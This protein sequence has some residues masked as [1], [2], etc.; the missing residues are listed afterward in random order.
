MPTG[1]LAANAS[2]P[3]SNSVSSS[4][5][6]LDKFVRLAVINLPSQPLDV[7]INQIAVRTKFILPDLLAEL[8]ARENSV[9]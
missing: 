5:D 7:N 4:A 6:G 8:G 9:R 3:I 2:H 1:F